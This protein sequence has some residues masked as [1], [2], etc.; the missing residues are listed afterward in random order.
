MAGNMMA[1]ST[2][3]E[4]AFGPAVDSSCRDG[5]DFTLLFEES[6]LTVL[7]LGIASKSPS[8]L[9]SIFSWS[10]FSWHNILIKVVGWALM[11]IFT[12]RNEAPKK[13]ASWPLAI[14]MVGCDF[15]GSHCWKVIFTV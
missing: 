4:D 5:F 1:C 15:F 8:F 3:A 10:Y 14:K 13:R 11:R 6:I 12:R 9:C 7:P 2:A